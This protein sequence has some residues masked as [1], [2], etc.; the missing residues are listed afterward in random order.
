[1]QSSRQVPDVARPSAG[2][3]LDG[4]AMEM[5]VDVLKA[6]PFIVEVSIP[7]AKSESFRVSRPPPRAHA[8]VRLSTACIVGGCPAPIQ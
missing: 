1:M 3:L 5:T 8:A 7:P 2:R 4:N 6:R